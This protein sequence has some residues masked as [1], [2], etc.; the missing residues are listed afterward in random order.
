MD[1]EE[2]AKTKRRWGM[3]SRVA[4][5][6][7][8]VKIMEFLWQY[9]AMGG[10]R[11]TDRRYAVVYSVRLRISK[12]TGLAKLQRTRKYSVPPAHQCVGKAHPGPKFSQP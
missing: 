9:G 10:R 2:K 4:D 1:A 11:D 8:R 6:G 5:A 3:V 7:R 12:R